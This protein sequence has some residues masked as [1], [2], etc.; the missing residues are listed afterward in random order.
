MPQL[1]PTRHLVASAILCLAALRAA[2][3]LAETWREI[4][5]PHF[6]VITDGSEH[7]GRDVAKEFEQMRSVLAARFNNPKLETGAPLL[8]VAVREPGLHELG[9]SMW[10]DRDR[11]AGEFFTGWERQFAMVRLDNFGDLNQVVVFHEYAHSVLHANI[12]WLPTWMDEGMAEFYAYTRFQS[13][14]VLV[15]AP[16][17]RLRHLNSEVLLP[18]PEML[19]AN[20]RTF[21]KD[22]RREDLFYGQAWLMIHYMTF[23]PEMNSGAKL[24]KF[25]SLL[26]SG[27]AQP[28]AFQQIFGDPKQFEDKLEQYRTRFAISAAVFPPQEKLDVQTFPA[29]VLTAAETNYELGSFEIGIHE[30]VEGKK[31]LDAAASADPAI[32]GVHEELGFVAWMR[33]QD[34]EA[35]TEWQKA[36]QLDPARYRAA[37]ALLMSQGN[38]ADLDTPH[39]QETQ[40]ALEAIQA[41]APKFAPVY[42]ELALIEWRQRRLNK[43][44]KLALAA[45]TLEPWRAGYHLLTGYILLQGNQAKMA[46]QSARIVATR[47]PGSD[48]DEAVDLWKLVP[49][50]LRAEGP[51]LTLATPADS[52]LT[53]GTIVR[54]ACDKSG[55]TVVLQPDGTGAAPLNLVAS[56]RFESGF[57]DTLW[58]GEDHYTPCFHLAG[59]QAVVAYKPDGTAPGKLVELEVRDELPPVILPTVAPTPAAR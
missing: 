30:Q 59:L 21:A 32:A 49:S 26:E 19:T 2:P 41:K 13:G 57:S 48:H 1:P 31:R 3:S 42:V 14:R 16:S 34:A 23:G 8:V 24:N 43:A 37:F 35:R 25:I 53:R 12:H 4:Q 9:P 40:K 33:G 52:T 47:W 54:T 39:L 51:A 5:S 50:E 56:G 46:E 58:F 6:R 15:G 28:Q 55:V 18:I 22:P 27:T 38:L 17:V 29:R 45:E 11:V 7:E 44:Y 10:K 20:S 36:V